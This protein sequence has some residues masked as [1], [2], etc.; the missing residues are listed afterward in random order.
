[1]WSVF[2]VVENIKTL[3]SLLNPDNKPHARKWTKFE[4]VLLPALFKSTGSKIHRQWN[5]MVCITNN[6]LHLSVLSF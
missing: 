5:I 3:L 1:M 6:T 2:V 4:M